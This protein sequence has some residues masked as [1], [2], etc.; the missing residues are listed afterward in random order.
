MFNTK[1]LLAV[2]EDINAFIKS[3][4]ADQK[5]LKSILLDYI[6]KKPDLFDNEKKERE[7]VIESLK[8]CF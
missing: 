7:D 5:R 2:D 3:F 8:D 1:L 4:Q 6:D